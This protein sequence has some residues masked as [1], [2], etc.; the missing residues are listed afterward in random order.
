MAP[1]S[2]MSFVVWSTLTC[3][4]RCTPAS[5]HRSS[6][7][8]IMSMSSSLGSPLGLRSNMLRAA[9]KS[10]PS[11]STR[12]S[13]ECEAARLISSLHVTMLACSAGSVCV[14]RVVV[15]ER[16]ELSACERNV[17]VNALTVCSWSVFCV[18]GVSHCRV[19]AWCTISWLSG[20]RVEVGLCCS[21][22]FATTWVGLGASLE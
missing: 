13:V 21:L 10:S 9:V 6:A 19:G 7:V 20:V 22:E 18:A 15:Y 12:S 2:S 17:S 11:C 14:R 16:T 8:R 1:V 5:A 3:L 4:A